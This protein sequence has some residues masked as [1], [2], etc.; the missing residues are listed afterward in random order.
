[1]AAR[2]GAASNG[3]YGK[4][5]QGTEVNLVTG[6]RVDHID[7]VSAYPETFTVGVPVARIADPTR[8]A[9]I[10]PAVA[11]F[12]AK[13]VET[14]TL[15]YPIEPRIAGS[16][17]GLQRQIRRACNATGYAARF[18]PGKVTPETAQ[19]MVRIARRPTSDTAADT[20]AEPANESANE[21]ATD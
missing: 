13:A 5:W 10:E 2:S 7:A 11:A 16:A 3:E 12:I 6:D 1:M 4:N 9:P 14:P 19:F 15:W 21:P 8:Q 20:A 17:P 18:K